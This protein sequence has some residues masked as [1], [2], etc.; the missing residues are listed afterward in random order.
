MQ[1]NYECFLETTADNVIN[2]QIFIFDGG[3][4]R[5]ESRTEYY[6]MGILAIRKNG[7]LNMWG[8]ITYSRGHVLADMFGF[9]T[10]SGEIYDLFSLYAA[11]PYEDL[12]NN[13]NG[14]LDITEIANGYDPNNE[15]FSNY[16]IQFYRRY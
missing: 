11:A 4:V 13:I 16:Y 14:T 9:S 6:V 12:A 3:V 7:N 10:A 15:A 2:K 8:G 5:D 1:R